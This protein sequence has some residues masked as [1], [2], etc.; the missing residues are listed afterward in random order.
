MTTPLNPDTLWDLI[1]RRAVLTP[2]R[3]LAIDERDRTL[4]FLEL[5]D[6]AER[7]AAA[8]AVEHRVGVGTPVAWQLPTR[9]SS[10]VLVGALARLGAVQV[11]MLPIYRE[12]EVRFILAQ[13]RPALVVVPSTWRGFGYLQLAERIIDDLGLPTSVLVCDDE[14]PEAEAEAEHEADRATDRWIARATHQATHTNTTIEGARRSGDPGANGTDPVRWIFYSSGTTGEPKGALH[15][16]GSLFAGSAGVVDAYRIT[17]DDRYPMVFPFTHV[18]GIGML[19]I[20]LLS[21]ASAVAVE[22]FDPEHTPPLLARHGITI[23]AGGTPLALVWL[24]QQRRHPTQPLFPLVRAVMT[25]AAPKPPAMHAE[26]KRELGCSG[27]LSCYGLTEVPFLTVSSVDDRD[28]DRALTEGRPIGG[29]EVRIVGPDE[30]SCPTGRVGEIRARGPQVCRGYLDGS[31]DAEAFDDEGWFRT[32]DLGRLDER[33]NLVVTG[34]LKEI[35]IRKGE[36]ISAKEIEDVLYDHP[37]IAD[38]AVIGLPDPALGELCCAVVVLRRP[39]NGPAAE[40]TDGPESGPITLAAIAAHCRRA[41]LAN[42]KV[43]ERVEIVDELPRNAS[44]KI[45]KYQLVERFSAPAR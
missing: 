36:N 12:R 17:Q 42:Q 44:G 22:Q 38:V 28:D 32:G 40:R 31:R 23:A 6:R 18:G 1:E 26:L 45:L 21:G 39:G 14:L 10:M 29:A 8:L 35:I 16:D 43:P 9:L 25:G 3:V 30:Q 4:S 5:R 27:A 19:V 37:A 15:T 11:P 20:Q 7:V 41:G 34:R 24:Q 2:D 33:G 13:V